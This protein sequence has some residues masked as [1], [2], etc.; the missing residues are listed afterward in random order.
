ILRNR[1]FSRIVLR[2]FRWTP[3]WIVGGAMI[4]RDLNQ[5]PASWVSPLRCASLGPFRPKNSPSAIITVAFL[6]CRLARNWTLG[7]HAARASALFIWRPWPTANPWWVRALGR[8][9]N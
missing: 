8:L 7:S 1:F 2:Q 5:R 3:Y 6:P 9:R 4:V